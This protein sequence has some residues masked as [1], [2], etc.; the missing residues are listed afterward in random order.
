MIK[1]LNHPMFPIFKDKWRNLSVAPGIQGS[2]DKIRTPKIKAAA[3]QLAAVAAAATSTP[4]T[5]ANSSPV[6]PLPRSGSFDLSIDENSNIAVDAKNVPRSVF[7]Y[8]LLLR[9]ST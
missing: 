9:A 6:A 1:N 7:L 3:F 8:F 2:K 5:S 4:T